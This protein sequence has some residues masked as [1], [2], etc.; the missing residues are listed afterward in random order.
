MN[1]SVRGDVVAVE[2]FEGEWKAPA[3]AAVD[4]DSALFC[5]FQY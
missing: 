5:P 3:D 4:Q 1:H 2:V